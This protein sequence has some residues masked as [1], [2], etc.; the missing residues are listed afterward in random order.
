M[1]PLALQVKPMVDTQGTPTQVGQ[2]MTTSNL[3]RIK[4]SYIQKLGG[5]THLTTSAPFTGVATYIRPWA[6][7]VGTQYVGIGTTTELVVLSAGTLTDITPMAGVGSGYWSMDNWGQNLIAAPQGG[8]IYQWIPP[9]S[10]GNIAAPLLNAPSEVNGCIVAAP[11]QQIIAWGVFDGTLGEQNPLLIQWCDVADNTDWTLSAT[12]Q[13]GSFPI[14]SGTKVVQII[15]YGLAGLIWT[16]LDF[17]SMTYANF[18]LIYGFNKIAP[19]C[20]LI[21]PRAANQ[22]G[23]RVAWMSQN[24]FFQYAGGQVQAVECT[25]RDFVFNNLDR[26]Y[27]QNI[28]CDTNTFYGE[29]MWRFPTIGSAGVC[30]AYVKWSPTENNAW[31]FGLGLPTISAWADESVI[32][33]PIGADYNGMIQ[34]FET[35]LDFDGVAIDNGFT[36]GWFY[37]AEGQEF[38]FLER[39]MPDF[40]LNVGGAVQITIEVADEIPPDDTDYP[41]RV[42]GP[43]PVTRATPYIIVRARGRVAR[44]TLDCTM[45]GTFWRY[46]KPLATAAIDG[47]QN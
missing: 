24:D 6:S 25:V 44:L 45:A 35:A 23:T 27:T 43:Y 22:L 28:H 33:A 4:N 40:T 20:G 7:L 36:T 15:W 19:N 31:D 38:I 11:E 18:P 42:Y 29:F 5:S 2:G 30:N 10:G 3:L 12:N 34:Q 21:G 1:Q 47:R 9:V 8:T 16:D 37:L 39:I 46:G 17:W 32:G 14:T 13:A 26:N 41:V